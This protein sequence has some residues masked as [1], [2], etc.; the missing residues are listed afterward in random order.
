[1]NKKYLEVKKFIKE[2][3]N[4]KKILEYLSNYHENDLADILISLGSEERK[5]I[6]RLL[7]LLKTAEIFTYYDEPEKYLA[8]LSIESA[9]RIISLMDSDDAV[10]VLERLEPERKSKIVE[11]LD[12]HA[13]QDV[14]KL[15]SYAEDEIGSYMT[16]NFV[17]IKEGLSIRQAMSEVVRQAGVHDNIMTV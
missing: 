4:D 16:T 1:M 3:N 13:A 11:K 6:Y 14:R 12:S 9:A 2:N 7:G 17:W 10:D 15:L 5:R 8:E